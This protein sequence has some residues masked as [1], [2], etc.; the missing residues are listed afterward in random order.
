MEP[1]E[2]IAGPAASSAGA[3]TLRRRAAMGLR[4]GLRACWILFRVT[5]PTYVVM[6]LLARLGVIAA[7]GAACAPLMRLFR[8]PGEAAIPILLG[9]LVN[10]YSATAAAGSLAL[11]GGQIVTL[12]LMLG[13][14]HT[15]VVETMVLR[16]A[17][18]RAVTLLLYRLAM[19]IL[20]ALVVS[21]L[22]I[23][24]TP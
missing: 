13:F 14:A 9:Y 6:D 7:I 4:R 24:P 1:P 5:V 10:L 17:R 20:A 2:D 15:L 18:A 23:G 19:S 12:G 16:A 3:G 22:L 11:S 21:R 8:L